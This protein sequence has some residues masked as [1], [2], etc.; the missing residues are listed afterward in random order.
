M[1]KITMLCG[2][3]ICSD[4][5]FV[6]VTNNCNVGKIWNTLSVRRDICL[7]NTLGQQLTEHTLCEFIDSPLPN[8]SKS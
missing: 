5:L 3:L 4:F 1:R 6:L 7:G 8:K 2:D